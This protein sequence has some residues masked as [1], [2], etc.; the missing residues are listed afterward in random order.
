MQTLTQFL[1]VEWMP[2][3]MRV[4]GLTGTQGE[5]RAHPGDESLLGSNFFS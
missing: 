1:P 2:C 4:A 3:R 5:H